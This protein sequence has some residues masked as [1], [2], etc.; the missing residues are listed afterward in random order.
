MERLGGFWN[1]VAESG[2]AI[3][4][5]TTT[6]NTCGT[7]HVLGYSAFGIPVRVCPKCSPLMV[8]ASRSATVADVTGQ[9][10][11]D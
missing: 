1:E 3:N 11:R 2:R 10:D 4:A 8:R 7:T 5:H 6:C 9:H